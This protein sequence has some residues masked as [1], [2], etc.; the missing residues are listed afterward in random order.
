MRSEIVIADR[1]TKIYRVYPQPSDH[2]KELFSFG[3][4]SYHRDFKALDDVSF[5]L[6]RGDRLGIVGENGSGKST[7]LKVLSGVL[8]P[9]TG[10]YYVGGRLTSLLELGTGFNS[11][12]SGEENVFQNGMLMGYS[13][14]EMAKRYPLIHDFS[15][16]GDFIK[17]P[18]KTYSSGMLVRLAFACAVFVDPEILIIDEAL[19]VGDAYFQSKCFYKIKSLLEK[20]ATFIYVSHNYDSIKTLCNKGLMLDQGRVVKDG[21]S[22]LVSDFY[23]KTI[24]EKQNK[25]RWYQSVRSGEENTEN[26]NNGDGG[27]REAAAL[28]ARLEFRESERFEKQVA[29]LRTGTG[30]A[31]IRCV[32]LLNSSGESIER[33]RLGEDAVIRVYFE[34]REQTSPNFSIG[35]GIC[36]DKGVQVLQFTTS[37]EGLLLEGL[38]PGTRAIVDFRF[39]NPLAPGPYNIKLGI[40]DL[41]DSPMQPGYR[42]IEKTIDYCVGGFQFDVSFDG[43]Q[44]AVWGKVA[45]PVEVSRVS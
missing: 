32:E 22:Q 18:I 42:I 17:Q 37:D 8:T 23:V 3:R 10:A 41:M 13:H 9:S 25:S 44:K 34:V 33:L 28:G 26:G 12:L 15:E 36:D 20:G 45:Y 14:Q 6:H 2:L 7:L 4:C 5:T 16:L 43:V 1:L 31:L 40:A 21:D 24:L 19:S 39:K 35:V 29:P 30:E 38:R 11:E 27:P